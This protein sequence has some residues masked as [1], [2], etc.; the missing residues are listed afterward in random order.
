MG[1]RMYKPTALFTLLT[2]I[3]SISASA[4]SPDLRTIVPRGAQRGTDLDVIFNG[5]RLKD[6]Q[7]IILYDKGIEVTKLE[8][9][10]PE[11]VKVHFKIAPDAPLG[12]HTMR[13]RSAS[14]ISELRSFWVGPFPTT[15]ASTR[16]VNTAWETSQ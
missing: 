5:Q 14:G 16:P 15:Q 11:Q 2:L 1:V 13:L 9:L 6:A 12:E 3:L 10:K 8:A 4:A 7:E